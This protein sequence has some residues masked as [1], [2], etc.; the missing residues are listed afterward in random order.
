MRLVSGVVKLN[1]GWSTLSGG[2]FV[3]GIICV[4]RHPLWPNGDVALIHLI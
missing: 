3:S 1:L 2:S 4:F